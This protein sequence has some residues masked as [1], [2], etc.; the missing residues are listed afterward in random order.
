[1][2]SCV[3]HGSRALA[4]SRPTE[5]PW[6]EGCKF[7]DHARACAATRGTTMSDAAN[8]TDA[9]R[10]QP[11]KLR[12]VTRVRELQILVAMLRPNDRTRHHIEAALATVEGLLTDGLDRLPAP[13]AAHLNRWLERHKH[14]GHS[15]ATPRAQRLVDDARPI[16][17][18]TRTVA[19]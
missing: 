2:A 4:P 16:A 1:L 19:R 11:L 8:S 10:G 6:R 5:R 9:T 18:W 7:C 17:F 15:A 14:L 13:V 3:E 12:V